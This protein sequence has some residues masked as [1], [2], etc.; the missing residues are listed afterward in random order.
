MLKTHQK[1]KQNTAESPTPSSRWWNDRSWIC[2]K[3]WEFLGALPEGFPSYP[4]VTGAF[5][6]IISLNLEVNMLY[7]MN[8]PNGF[9]KASLTLQGTNISHQG[10]RKIVFKTALGGSGDML[11]LWR[12]P[13]KRLFKKYSLWF[14]VLEGVNFL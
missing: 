13:I 9:L 2:Q 6:M 5:V 7:G 14:F 3:T 11:I 4:L 10:K 12:V 1:K 8:V